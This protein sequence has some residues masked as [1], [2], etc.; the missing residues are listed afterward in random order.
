MKLEKI[1]K[2]NLRRLALIAVIWI[3]FVVLHNIISGLLNIEEPVFFTIAVIVI[4]VY[5]IISLIYTAFFKKKK[6]SGGK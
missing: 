5:L 6:K 3:V 2:L 4:P 1:L